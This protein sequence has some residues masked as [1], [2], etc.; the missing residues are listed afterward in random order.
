MNDI[1]EGCGLITIQIK[2]KEFTAWYKEGELSDTLSMYKRDLEQFDEV[3]T[4]E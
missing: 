4:N 2:G 3:A 1:P